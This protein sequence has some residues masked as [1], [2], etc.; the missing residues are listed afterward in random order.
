MAAPEPATPRRRRW[1]ALVALLAVLALFAL[2]LHWVSRPSR[3]AGLILAQAGNALGL[4]IT[5][6][7][8]SEYRLRGTPMLSVR[9]LVVRLPGEKTPVLTAERIQL[10]VPWSTIRARGADLTVRRIEL[11]APQLDL[12]ALQR[13]LATR[14]PSEEARIPTLTDGLRIVRGRVF[15]DGW[16]VDAIDADLPSLHPDRPA[17]AHLRGRA[18]SGTLRIPFDVHVALTRPAARAGLGV[19]GD[20]AVQSP[21]WSLPMRATL[22]GRLHNGDDGIGLDRLRLGANATW[23]SGETDVRFTFGLAGPVRLL[24]GELGIAPAGVTLWGDA[25]VPNLEAAG[26]IGF[27]ERLALHLQGALSSWPRAWPALPSPLVES[28]SPLPFALDYLG[29]TDLSDLTSLRLQRDATRFD[30]RFRIASVM[31]W[32]DRIDRDTPLPP[33]NGRLSTPKLVIAGATF[34]GV[35]VEFSEDANP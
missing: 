21:T 25:V 26:R 19:A 28:T 4:E 7:S 9:D 32:M 13:W 31:D 11:D 23:R 33:L 3:V 34:E 17:R 16:S 2:A 5:A 22:S 27:G 24:G 14:P 1:I 20:I 15:G 12:A 6:G 35:D 8:T 18:L 30:G 29:R 10:E